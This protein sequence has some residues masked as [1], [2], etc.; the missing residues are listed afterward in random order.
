MRSL[1]N[2]E[3]YREAKE[4]YTRA[5]ALNPT[6]FAYSFR[7]DAY[8]KLRDY[9]KAFADYNKLVEL[10]P[11]S[12]MSYVGRGNAYFALGDETAAL[13]DFDRLLALAPAEHKLVPVI[14]HGRGMLRLNAKDYQGAIADCTKTIESNTDEQTKYLA[15]QCRAR[16]YAESGEVKLAIA[17]YGEIIKRQP[18]NA[19]AY[20]DRASYRGQVEDYQGALADFTKAI[21]IKPDYADAY[22]FRSTIKNILQD[23]QGAIDDAKKADELYTQQI[24]SDP[25]DLNLYTSR[26]LARVGYA[27]KEGALQDLD[28]AEELSRAQGIDNTEFIQNIRQM[29]QK[30]L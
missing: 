30:Y 13:A 26:A 8:F 22:R 12:F 21:E 27:N 3:R 24:A 19:S 5:I 20:Y 9:P 1:P 28:K 14:Y 6:Y 16:A 11:N 4:S 2:L 17:E 7:G 18:Q 25:S 10:Q 29:I 15:H 23:F